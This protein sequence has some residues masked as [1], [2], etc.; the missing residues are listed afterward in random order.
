MN[1]LEKMRK[2]V[3]SGNHICVGLDTDKKLIPHHLLNLPDPLF[4]FNRAIID[5]TGAMAG[6]FKLNFAFYEKEGAYGSDVLKRSVSYILEQYPDVLIIGDAKR[7]DIGN[8]SAY[9]AKALFDEVG[10]DA[11]TLSP[12][13]GVESLQPFFDYH[14]KLHFVLA[15]TSNPGAAD[16]EKLL[17]ADGTPI[18]QKVIHTFHAANTNQNI[19]FVIGATQQQELEEAVGASGGMPI[20]LPGVGAQG[21][22][23]VNI[24]ALFNRLRHPLYLI[25]SSRGIIYANRSEGYAEAA[26]AAMKALQQEISG[27]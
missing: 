19:G 11:S 9:Y 2:Q 10:V 22:S 20:L 17:L 27:L 3:G 23:A 6:A 12:Y 25:N 16:F 13:M 14:D 7:G 8:S 21:A 5:A 26:K 18:Y 1:A 15:L 4:E 24:A